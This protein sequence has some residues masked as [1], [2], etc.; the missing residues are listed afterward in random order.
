MPATKTPIGLD[1]F[2]ADKTLEV[3]EHP[4]DV[5]S[6]TIDFMRPHQLIVVF[7]FYARSHFN[8]AFSFAN[9]I[10]TSRFLRTTDSIDASAARALSSAFRSLSTDA[11]PVRT[12]AAGRDV[13]A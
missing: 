9:W 3:R 11:S 4:H 5:S 10:S 1:L 7:F 6:P 2:P 8:I 12:P 13:T